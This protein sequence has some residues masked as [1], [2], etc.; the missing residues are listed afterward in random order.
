MS[1]LQFSLGAFQ[2]LDAAFVSRRNSRQV[3]NE[4]G[5]LPKDVEDSQPKPRVFQSGDWGVR[6]WSCWDFTSFSSPRNNGNA[7]HSLV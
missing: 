5:V 7:T 6:Q 2:P 1:W 3:A 4:I